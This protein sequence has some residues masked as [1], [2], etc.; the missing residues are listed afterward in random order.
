MDTSLDLTANGAREV[1]VFER[2]LLIGRCRPA[3]S[4]LCIEAADWMERICNASNHVAAAAMTGGS[5]RT[6]GVSIKL[7]GIN[8]TDA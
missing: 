6:A 1:V 8:E 4:A 3:Y 2:R 7:G 5:D